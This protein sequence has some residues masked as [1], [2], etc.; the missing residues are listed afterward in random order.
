MALSFS[1][2]L[3][4]RLSLLSAAASRSTVRRPELVEGI[5]CIFTHEFVVVAQQFGQRRDCPR[6]L[7]AAQDV[8]R[9][10]ANGNAAAELSDERHDG[11]GAD[12]FQRAA[13]LAET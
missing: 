11:A 12:L 10:T 3:I 8:R 9:M 2:F 13:V 6:V 4:F 7:D 5:D 1:S